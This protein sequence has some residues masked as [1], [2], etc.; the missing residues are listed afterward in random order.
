MWSFL[1]SWTRISI[2]ILDH[3]T[4]KNLSEPFEKFTDWEWVQ[5]LASDL[6]SPRI[7]ITLE[8]EADKAVSNFIA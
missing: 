1:I 6:I 8:E 3:I 4:I 7:E 5:S 2:H